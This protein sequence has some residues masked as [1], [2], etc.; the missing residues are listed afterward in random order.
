MREKSWEW[1]ASNG[2]AETLRAERII[3]MAFVSRCVMFFYR[4]L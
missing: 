3:K 1:N 4:S 2:T